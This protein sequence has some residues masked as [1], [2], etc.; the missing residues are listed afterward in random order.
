MVVKIFQKG[1][2]KI[3]S[4]SL[5]EYDPLNKPLINLH[6]IIWILYRKMSV[7]NALHVADI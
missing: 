7:T 1:R 2:L 3:T 5:Q 4:Y 6:V